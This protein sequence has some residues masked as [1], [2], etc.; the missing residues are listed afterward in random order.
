MD[1]EMH[2]GYDELA[3]AQRTPVRNALELALDELKHERNLV[4][5]ARKL[6]LETIDSIHDPIMV[7]DASHRIVR[8]NKAYAELAGRGFLELLGRPYW[9][10]FPRQQGPLPGC[11]QAACVQGGREEF[12]TAE[13]EQYLS[14]SF[15][16]RSDQAL[17]HTLH[18]FENVTEERREEEARR[19]CTV[20]GA[21][22]AEA[23]D[24]I[25]MSSALVAGSMTQLA[26]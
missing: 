10:C 3:G 4:R 18:I 20:R 11:I 24:V 21:A 6:W 7:H 2:P 5:D 15:L 17:S 16:L 26:R 9:E 23:L 25:S 22:Y 19:I 13:G 8:A 12:A 14:K 1:I